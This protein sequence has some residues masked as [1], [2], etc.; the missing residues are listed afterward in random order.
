VR[1]GCSAAESAQR[2]GRRRRLAQKNERRA[3]ACRCNRAWTSQLPASRSKMVRALA[4]L[5][6]LPAAH[7]LKVHFFERF[8]KI[9]LH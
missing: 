8:A 2:S 6:L 7:A 5:L 3:K 4:V 9:R 1:G